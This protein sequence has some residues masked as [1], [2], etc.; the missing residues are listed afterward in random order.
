MPRRTFKR[1]ILPILLASACDDPDLATD[2]GEDDPGPV[3]PRGGDGTYG[4]SFRLNTAKLFIEGM[5]VRHF[6][7][8]GAEV[9]YDNAEKTRV[10]FQQ[11]RLAGGGGVFSAAEH[12][13]IVDRGLVRIDGVSYSAGQLLG[14]QWIFSVRDKLHEAR[15]VS[16]TITGVG[17]AATPSGSLP[18]YN[19]TLASNQAFYES[20]P[21]SAC[22]PL[23]VT[24][25]SGLTTSL[26]EAT[27]P[28][29]ENRFKAQYAATL[30][31]GAWASESGVIATNSRFITLAC[32][33]GAVGKA[34]LWGYPPWVSSDGVRT[35]L[36]QLQAVT[37]AIRADYCGD[38]QAHTV[39]GTPIQVR[40]RYYNSFF[41]P[42][43]DTEAVFGDNGAAC[44]VEHD[45]L[46]S[47][48]SW[49]CG[50]A[51]TTD[52]R[53]SAADYLNGATTP[54]MWVKVDPA[55]AT[56]ITSH[57]CNTTGIPGCSDPGIEAV[58]CASDPYCC[59]TEWDS[60]CVDE[61]VEFAAG[62]QACCSA[63]GGPGCADGAVAACVGNF[64][65]SCQTTAWDF[66]CAIEVEALGCG[67]CH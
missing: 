55:H 58:V 35:G 39:D 50:G 37:R 4:G 20:G 54:F 7:R 42:P 43:E 10:T 24:T 63:H 2:L 61:V 53:Q 33:S 40:D 14:S 67:Q 27:P 1:L 46:F 32:L 31:G 30:Y 47:G 21:F 18:V 62:E 8:R 23:D 28:D 44:K 25:T 29:L 64:D 6:D 15:G 59:A 11:L 49:D 51:V 9:T 12:T 16:M 66:T 3:T 13:I 19:F 56:P 45:R 17:L 5:P 48:S 60:I 41:D 34:G 52:C 57:K 65:P 36:Q 22:A 38:G 26:P